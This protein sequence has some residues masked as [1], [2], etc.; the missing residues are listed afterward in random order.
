MDTGEYTA[1]EWRVAR[2]TGVDTDQVALAHRALSEQLCTVEPALLGLQRLYCT[3]ML[4]PTPRRMTFRME[5]CLPARARR[6]LAR[7]LGEM[8]AIG[9]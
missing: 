5:G 3:Q 7:L 6:P 9:S 4:V 2:Q 8:C 1:F